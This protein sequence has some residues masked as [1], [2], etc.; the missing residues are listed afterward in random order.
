ME[1]TWGFV[2]NEKVQ[3]DPNLSGIEDSY[4]SSSIHSEL[5]SIDGKLLGKLQRGVNI[6]RFRNGKSQKVVVK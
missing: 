5:Y 3:A 1:N 6:I 4:V 2:L